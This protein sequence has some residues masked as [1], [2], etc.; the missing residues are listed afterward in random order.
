[1]TRLGNTHTMPLPAPDGSNS[2]Q[3]LKNM[4]EPTQ[5]NPAACGAKPTEPGS[6]VTWYGGPVVV[7]NSLTSKDLNRIQEILAVKHIAMVSASAS[8]AN[9]PA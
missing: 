1:M 3:Q 4:L 9:K 5:R 2:V 7:N 8:N 6:E